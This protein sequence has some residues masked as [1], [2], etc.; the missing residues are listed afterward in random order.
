MFKFSIPPTA[1]L[2][3]VAP[4]DTTINNTMCATLQN[5]HGLFV[6]VQVLHIS[7][8]THTVCAKRYTVVDRGTPTKWGA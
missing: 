3:K 6:K 8:S 7:H 1:Q 5:S 2:V 4:T